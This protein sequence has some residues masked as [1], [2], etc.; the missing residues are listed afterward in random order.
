MNSSTFS[1]NSNRPGSSSTISFE[2]NIYLYGYLIIFSFGFFGHIISLIIFRRDS[3]R[4]ESTSQ[5]FINMTISNIIYLLTCFYHF[6]FLGFNISITNTNLMNQLCRIYSFFQYFSM[7]SSI[8][9]L[10]TITIDRWIRIYYPFRVKQL[11]TKKRVHIGTFIII[12][13]S[14]FLNFHLLLPSTEVVQGLIACSV[15]RSANSIYQYF[16]STIWPILITILQIIIPT[17]IL[18]ILSIN[19]YI[20]LRCQQQTLQSTRKRR[21]FIERQIFIIMISSIILFFF[22]QIPLSL[23][24]ILMTYVL[25]SKLTVQQLFQFN[26]IAILIASINYAVSFYIHCLSSRLFRQEF[27]NVLHIMRNHRVNVGTQFAATVISQSQSIQL[28]TRK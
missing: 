22:T 1:N 25:R 21:I 12:I 28:K 23:F 9:L 11:C 10:L 4:K 8:W 17:T 6:L 16:Y 3:L 20:K 2:R 14:I 5:L 7:C 18:I 13:F 15:S 27:F 19:I 24:Y 26:S